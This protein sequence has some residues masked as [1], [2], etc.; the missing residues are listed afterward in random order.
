MK[1]LLGLF[2]VLVMLGA[3]CAEVTVDNTTP[4]TS[5]NGEEPSAM[6]DAT[7]TVSLS[8]LKNNI[9]D[10]KKDVS[11]Y[12]YTADSGTCVGQGAPAVISYHEDTTLKYFVVDSGDGVYSDNSVS[13]TAGNLITFN[14][15]PL[16]GGAAT[17]QI[18]VSYG[19]DTGTYTCKIADKEVC[20]STVTATATMR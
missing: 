14:E 20:A 6:I 8:E 15:V 19:K 1:K 12:V 17:C 7:L 9:L 10:A 18:Q 2:A 13:A 5:A 11:A 3:G 16:T 4:D